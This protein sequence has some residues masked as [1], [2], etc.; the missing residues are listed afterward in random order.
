MEA[1]AANTCAEV[2]PT[3]GQ[4]QQE[5]SILVARAP[6]LPPRSNT[7]SL[8]HAGSV[9]NDRAWIISTTYFF[10]CGTYR[11]SLGLARPT[12]VSCGVSAPW[13]MQRGSRGT[14]AL[15][16]E[17]DGA[18]GSSGKAHKQRSPPVGRAPSDQGDFVTPLDYK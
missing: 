13:L 12:A 4:V 17:T 5:L 2:L 11:V 7:R 3:D 1:T 16:P 10:P 6:S 14:S 9:P 15:L 8:P 18:R